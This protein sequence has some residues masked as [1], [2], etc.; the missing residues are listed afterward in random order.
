[1]SVMGR[2]SDRPRV[3]GQG[4]AIRRERAPV[5]AVEPR[6]PIGAVSRLTG[7]PV[8]TLRAWERR[9]Q[10]VAPT[11]TDRGR[12]Y[13]AAD[14]ARLRLLRLAVARG[15]GI[16]QVAGLTKADLERL[17][18]EIEPGPPA[19]TADAGPTTALVDE[20]LAALRE[21]QFPTVEHQLLSYALA[22]RPTQLVTELLLP[23]LDRKST[24]LNSSHT[25][26]SRMPSS[27]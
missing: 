3:K 24:R 27:A 5:G 1:M 21:Y 20:V 9:Y 2:R 19:G 7:I 15:H 10:V 17:L 8:D 25:D 6:Y 13:G 16:G 14:V 26:I 11:R 23:L 4:P 12:M 18:H 22:M